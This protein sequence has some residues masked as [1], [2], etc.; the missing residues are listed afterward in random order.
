MLF[1]RVT[2]HKNI[3]NKIAEF[4]AESE[5]DQAL[6]EAD[7]ELYFMNHEVD[8]CERTIGQYIDMYWE[9]LAEE[10]YTEEDGI[11]LEDFCCYHQIGQIGDFNRAPV[12]EFDSYKDILSYFD[13]EH[14]CKMIWDIVTS[15]TCS[16]VYVG[17]IWGD[18]SWGF[19][20][21]LYDECP[22]Y[23]S[24]KIKVK[25]NEVCSLV[26]TLDLD[27]EFISSLD[28]GNS[29]SYNVIESYNY[30]DEVKKVL[31]GMPVD[32]AIEYAK[33]NKVKI[34]NL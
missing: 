15:L 9:Q 10:G 14:Y 22:Q 31:L 32:D 19:D 11:S 26:L 33:S 16:D 12:P 18:G 21:K 5:G 1:L 13:D 2:E 24:R 20:E 3:I 28:C 30:E 23:V 29:Y 34:K 25:Y 17:D 6:Y 7:P 8:I 27:K 4:F